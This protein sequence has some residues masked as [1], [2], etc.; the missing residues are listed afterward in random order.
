ML[1]HETWNNDQW[2]I[3]VY[4]EATCSVIDS[5][6]TKVVPL[7]GFWVWCQVAGSFWEWSFWCLRAKHASP[8]LHL[9]FKLGFPQIFL[10]WWAGSVI[11]NCL[12][13]L[14]A[15][16]TR[17]WNGKGTSVQSQYLHH[18]WEQPGA[19]RSHVFKWGCS[20]LGSDNLVLINSILGRY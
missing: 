18:F 5:L 13:P 2:Y 16:E 3:K 10:L 11:F 6:L 19:K 8:T 14:N 12:D 20:F 15:C 4:Q 7:T 1:G 17:F 9:F